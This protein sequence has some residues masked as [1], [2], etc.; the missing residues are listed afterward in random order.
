V[1]PT[2]LQPSPSQNCA[3]WGASAEDSGRWRQEQHLDLHVEMRRFGH[4]VDLA[5]GSLRPLA[6]RRRY[7][8]RATRKPNCRQTF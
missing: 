4:R 3:P 2:H 6:G 1:R 7:V 8:W 5:V